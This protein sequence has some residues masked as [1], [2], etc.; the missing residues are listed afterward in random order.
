M[1]KFSPPLLSLKK[2]LNSK[3][4]QFVPI[5]L[6]TL[7]GNLFFWGT[8]AILRLQ[9]NPSEVFPFDLAPTSHCNFSIMLRS[10]QQYLDKVLLCMGEK[11]WLLCNI[12]SYTC[13]AHSQEIKY[14]HIT[15]REFQLFRFSP[16]H[17][18]KNRRQNKYCLSYLLWINK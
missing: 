16:K 17:V 11:V 10:V 5:E 7:T 12:H 18:N 2:N 6:C 1:V 15:C 3:S 13:L 8:K 9:R 4:P 14:T